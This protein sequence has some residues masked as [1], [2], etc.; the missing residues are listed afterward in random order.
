[1]RKKKNV[2]IPKETGMVQT[3]PRK[4]SFNYRWLNLKLGYRQTLLL[5]NCFG[6]SEVNLFVHLKVNFPT[7]VIWFKTGT[8]LRFDSML[9]TSGQCNNG[10]P[11]TEAC[12]YGGDGESGKEKETMPTKEKQKK[13]REEL[14]ISSAQWFLNLFPFRCFYYEHIS[15]GFV[16]IHCMSQHIFQVSGSQTN[17]KN[18]KL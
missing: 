9:L 15:H 8:L 13:S 14:E 17:D 4:L 12:V 18:Y 10:C 3:W 11:M 7:K 2:M 6:T 5:A 1:M 16:V